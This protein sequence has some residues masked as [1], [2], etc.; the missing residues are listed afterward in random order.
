MADDGDKP[1]VAA[2]ELFQVR[3]TRNLFRLSRSATGDLSR[4]SGR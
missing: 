2:A 4:S 3:E 1:K